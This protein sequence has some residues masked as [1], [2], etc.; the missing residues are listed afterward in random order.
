MT[1]PAYVVEKARNMRLEKRMTIDEIATRLA[2]P[3]TTIFYWVRDIVVPRSAFDPRPMSEARARAAAANREKHA[4]IREAAYEA[5]IAEFTSLAG[6]ATFVD[7]VCMYIGEGSKKSR[8]TVAICNSDPA[9][10]RLGHVWIS[11]LTRNKVVHALQY[12]ADQEPEKLRD[13]WGAT[14]QIEPGGIRLQRKSNS[15]QLGGRNW[16]S[17]W[18]VLMV[19]SSDVI[20]RARLGAWM[21]QTRARWP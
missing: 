21:D 6:Q 14:L 4:R 2:L 17:A 18:G 5:G 11:K 16:R 12:H 1:Y 7:F 20:L 19:C 9:V 8:H 3:R 13:F 15:G 10:V